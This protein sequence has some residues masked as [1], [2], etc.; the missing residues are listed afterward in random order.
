MIA[1]AGSPQYLDSGGWQHVDATADP[2][3]F[4]AYLEGAATLLR[5]RHR[6]LLRLLDVHAGCAVLDVGCGG[7]FLLTDLAAEINGITGVGID[8][9]EALLA[10][11][12][13]RARAAG[14]PV[15]FAVGDAQAL[16]FA[17]ASFDRVMCSRVLMHLDDPAGAVREMARVLRPGGRVAIMEPDFDSAMIDSDDLG[18]TRAVVAALARSLRNP[19]MGRRLRRLLLDAGL[20]DVEAVPSVAVLPRLGVADQQFGLLQQLENAV[21]AG[22]ISRAAGDAWRAWQESADGAGRFWLALVAVTA[23]ARK[24]TPHESA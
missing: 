15:T 4:A 23:A 21:M 19:D 9:S 5:E 22:A 13:T 2:Q 7:G 12:R 11:A 14:L 6:E 1:D 24:P 3:A 20:A 10:G 8:A 16:D 18:T 17:G